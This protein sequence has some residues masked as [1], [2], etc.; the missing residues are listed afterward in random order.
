MK[1][2][3]LQDIADELL[4]AA[5]ARQDNHAFAE[6]LRR[7]TNRFFKVAYGVVLDADDADEIVQDA[8]LKLWT[9]KAVWEEGRNNR[10]TTWFYRIVY[11]QALDLLRKK[12][13]FSVV[14]DTH[15]SDDKSADV[16]IEEAQERAALEHALGNLPER[17]R[18]ALMLYYKDELPQAECATIMGLNIKAFESLLTRGKQGLKENLAKY[19]KPKTG[20]QPLVKSIIHA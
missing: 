4:A 20:K 18:T 14:E 15:P 8:F 7:H 17:Q 19:H 6:L 10:F 12:P 9:G 5:V 11:N 2:P 16:L 13:R 1:Q 3:M